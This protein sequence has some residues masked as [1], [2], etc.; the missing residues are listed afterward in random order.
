[1]YIIL[2]AGSSFMIKLCSHE[3]YAEVI[4]MQTMYFRPNT[5]T[6]LSSDYPKTLQI[7]HKSFGW[8]LHCNVPQT[9]TKLLMTKQGNYLNTETV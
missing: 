7:P 4:M 2:P 1:M 8:L 5:R 6:D 9:E 3:I